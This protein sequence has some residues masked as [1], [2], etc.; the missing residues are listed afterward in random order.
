MINLEQKSALH[1]WQTCHLLC[2]HEVKSFANQSR[3]LFA[4]NNYSFFICLNIVHSNFQFHHHYDEHLFNDSKTVDCDMCCGRG[5][6]VNSIIYS[7]SF[8]ASKSYISL[9]V[10]IV[11]VTYFMTFMKLQFIFERNI[12]FN[13]VIF[14]TYFLHV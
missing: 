3:Q 4:I 9:A 13:L 10:Q 14:K 1:N 6:G 2:W 7:S 5:N 11:F 12:I 8:F